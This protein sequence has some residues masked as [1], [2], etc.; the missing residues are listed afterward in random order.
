MNQRHYDQIDI[1]RGIAILM[2]LLYHSILVYPIN[3]LELYPEAEVVHSFLYSVEMPVFFFVSGFCISYHGGYG[4]YLRKK[5]KRILLPHLVFGVLDIAVRVVASGFVS[6]SGG[7]TEGL[8][9]FVLYGGSDWFLLTLFILVLI[10]PLIQKLLEK[11][12]VGIGIA[13]FATMLLYLFQNKVPEV[14]SAKNVVNFLPFF[15]AGMGYRRM[16]DRAEQCEV[17]NRKGILG[18]KSIAYLAL[19]VGMFALSR[20]RGW[21]GLPEEWLK[22]FDEGSF[23]MRIREVLTIEIW[24]GLELCYIKWVYLCVCLVASALCVAA[25]YEIAM[26][27]R[28]SKA[29][30]VFMEASK[31]S[32]QLYLLDG[33]ALVLTRTLFVSVCKMQNP[34][35]VTILNFV[36]DTG[37]AYVVA[38][39]I[40]SRWKLLRLASGITDVN[41]GVK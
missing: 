11:K 13:I 16:K 37:I 14:L 25:V 32:L 1:C 5:M 7:W 12:A 22:V 20:W 2:V 19:G 40:L 4:Q 27:L 38:K 18:I 33:Y 9:D 10:A 17:K 24:N 3:F 41:G 15:V 39:C 35:V 8:L 34:W 21:T 23:M 6:T 26:L 36:I 31:Y 29:Q 28:G 30:A